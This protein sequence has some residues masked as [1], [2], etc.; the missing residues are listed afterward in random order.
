[1][2]N[3][4]VARVL[5]SPL[6]TTT[7]TLLMLYL[8]QKLSIKAAILFMYTYN[9]W[10]GVYSNKNIPPKIISREI[11]ENVCAGWIKLEMATGLQ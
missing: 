8:A 6:L 1:M 10:D 7:T 5:V 11:H 4:L 9:D 2:L 3:L